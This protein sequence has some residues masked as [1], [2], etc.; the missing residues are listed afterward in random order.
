MAVTL[1]KNA[2]S[3]N[4]GYSTQGL[5][6]C[7][8]CNMECYIWLKTRFLRGGMHEDVLVSQ[9]EWPQHVSCWRTY[10]AWGPWRRSRCSSC[11]DNVCHSY[12]HCWVII[13]EFQCLVGWTSVS[14]VL[15][16]HLKSTTLK[17]TSSRLWHLCFLWHIFYVPPL[18]LIFFSSGDTKE[19]SNTVN[20][21]LDT[22]W[23][24]QCCSYQCLLGNFRRSMYLNRRVMRKWE[25]QLCLM[26]FKRVMSSK[27]LP[28]VIKDHIEQG[29][30]H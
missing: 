21:D 15:H 30:G 9:T 24:L 10:A 1:L 25:Q 6:V 13:S 4:K 29:V 20:P 14:L 23:S 19:L 3:S 22:T 5:A 27:I 8:R 26:R 17:I 7:I 12:L 28:W 16:P 18:L 2:F 11:V